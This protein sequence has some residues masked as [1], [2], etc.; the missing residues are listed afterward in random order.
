M[1]IKCIDSGIIYKNPMPYLKSVHAYFPTVLQLSEHELVASFTLGE[2]FEA[3]NCHTYISR[4]LDGG[5][6]W[7]LEDEIYTKPKNRRTSNVGRMTKVSDDEIVFW[8][9][10]HDRK[11][12][13]RGLTNPDNMGFVDTELM[14][15]RSYDGGRSWSHPKLIDMPIVGPN[16]DMSNVFVMND[17]K[18]MVSTSTW[19][20]FDG[21]CPNGM[22]TINIISKDNGQSWPD[23]VV[24]MHDKNN[25]LIYVENKIIEFEDGRLM[26]VAWAVDT[27]EPNKKIPNQYVV[28]FDNGISYSEIK[29]TQIM[30]QTLSPILIGENKVMSVYRRTDN[31]GLWLNISLVE[32]DKWTNINDI[33]LW[34]TKYSGLAQTGDNMAMNFRA[35][36]FGA[37]H[38]MKM[39][40]GYILCSFWCVEDGI[41]IIRWFKLMV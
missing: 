8:M 26:V 11:H 29:S 12:K 34:G 36:Q 30:G 35:L 28:S 40:N 25:R 7:Q 9:T 16:Y 27:Q 22:K 31:P 6:T 5:N 41:S 24:A 20:G 38:L 17:G 32:G 10:R 33:P 3:V 37:P 4:S 2:A 21:Y 23:Y 18:W 1:T 39:T 15:L 14:I 13:N 19:C